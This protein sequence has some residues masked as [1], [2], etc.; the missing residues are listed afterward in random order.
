M[1]VEKVVIIHLCLATKKGTEIYT[2][3]VTMMTT[4]ATTMLQLL[5]FYIVSY[6]VIVLIIKIYAQNLCLI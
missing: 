4:V 5:K 6:L 3:K 1:Q 2:G